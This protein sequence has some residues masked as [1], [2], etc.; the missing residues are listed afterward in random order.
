MKSR[1]SAT[2]V[3]DAPPR[4]LTATGR[5][6]ERQSGWA[7]APSI[8]CDLLADPATPT[9][10]SPGR[11][12]RAFRQLPLPAS[13]LAVQPPN[14]RT[15]VNFETNFYTE[16]A[17]FTRRLRL[18][19]QRVDLKIRPSRF[20]W[21]FGDG[22]SES[23]SSPGAP[24]PR[25]LVTHAYGSRVGSVRGWTRPMRPTSASTAARGGR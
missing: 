13:E 1:A 14:G 20:T 18:L 8:F 3:V 11:V 15:L 5:A 12:A 22:R 17:P 19:G 6:F 10:T 4:I 24:Y 23:S 21:V 25:L 7:A 9:P 16:Q 2:P